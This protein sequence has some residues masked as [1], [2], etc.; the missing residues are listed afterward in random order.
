MAIVAPVLDRGQTC[1][2][3]AQNDPNAT[4]AAEGR[5]VALSYTSAQRDAIGCLLGCVA[6]PTTATQDLSGASGLRTCDS[7]ARGLAQRVAQGVGRLAR[8]ALKAG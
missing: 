8:W 1:C 6:A 7:S 4:R 2:G 5:H 3:N